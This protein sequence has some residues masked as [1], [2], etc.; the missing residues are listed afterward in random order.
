MYLHPAPDY[1]N[2]PV[3][4]FHLIDALRSSRI[5][6]TTAAPGRSR[7][8]TVFH[9]PATG[10]P[11]LLL[12]IADRPLRGRMHAGLESV[13]E[14]LDP[15]RNALKRGRHAEAEKLARRVLALAPD[16]A[17]ARD[18]LEQALAS[19]KATR[20]GMPESRPPR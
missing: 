5:S 9:D 1:L 14:L 11:V 16:S 13:S 18:I 2:A 10:Q 20:T 15:A 8:E 4:T 12:L 19:K 6:G 17:S 7:V 3:L